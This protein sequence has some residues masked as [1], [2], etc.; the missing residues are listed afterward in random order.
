MIFKITRTVS[1]QT[2][3]EAPNRNAALN[4]SYSDHFA[5]YVRSVSGDTNDE[6]EQ[7]GTHPRL[8]PNKPP[9]PDVTVDESGSPILSE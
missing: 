2:F 7:A 8:F 3:V 9:V 6:I 5:D 4:Y 1:V